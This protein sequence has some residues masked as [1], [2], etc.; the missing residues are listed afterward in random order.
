MGKLQEEERRIMEG[1]EERRDR[2]RGNRIEAESETVEF[3]G[4]EVMRKGRKEEK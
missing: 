4:G 2:R 3:S 1:K